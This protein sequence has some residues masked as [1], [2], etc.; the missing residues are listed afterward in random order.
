MNIE[1]SP[2]SLPHYLAGPGHP[3]S[4]SS[5]P[6]MASARAIPIIVGVGD[7]VNRSTKLED[8]IEPM[9]LM[10]QAT[11]L[12]LKDTNLAPAVAL[13]LQ[14]NID[15]IDVVRSWTWPY[16]DLPGL[17]SE[18]MGVH[19]QHT[20]YSPH[21]GNQP[22]KLFDEAA[23]R[24]SLRS[25]RVAVVTGGEALASLNA[26]AAAK[27]LPPPG[28]TKL[29]E[30]DT[31][32][33]VFSPTRRALAPSSLGARHAIGAPIHVYPLFENGLRAHRGQSLPE[34]NRESAELYADFAAVAQ[35]N[36]YAWNYGKQPVDT[37]ATIGTVTP[38]NRLICSPY[39]LKMNAF[40]TV[41][42][43]ATCILTSTDYATELGIPE[44]Q[45]VYPL[46]SAG[47]S[48]SADFWN[49]PTFHSSPAIARSLDTCLHLAGLTPDQIDLYDFYSCFPIVPKLA[50]RHLGLPVT[51]A[52]G[53][54][55][56]ITLLGG[57][58]SFGG[59]GNNYSMHVSLFFLVFKTSLP[60]WESS[61][62]VLYIGTTSPID[63]NPPDIYHLF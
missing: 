20:H 12:A 26:C 23:R 11:L 16:P 30:T 17:L 10:L 1:S 61:L 37:A 8:A 29:P 40:N 48:D 56:P 46:A 52:D 21:G 50:C 47:T 19:P 59:A 31:V 63:A 4:V 41:N 18:K 34:N 33:S 60:H 38:K 22:G 32:T 55:K 13:E 51:T 6:I 27:R 42:L 25:S 45:W 14:S 36:P 28:W 49:R 53:L 44:T 54:A 35:Q 3:F 58:T 24:I 43:A 39:P 2:N 62:D 57:L 15:S 5:Y 7:V 9:Q